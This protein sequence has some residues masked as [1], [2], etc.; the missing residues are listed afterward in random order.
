MDK[1]DDQQRG[2]GTANCEGA[3]L[4]RAC[5][6]PAAVML[7]GVPRGASTIGCWPIDRDGAIRMVDEG[8]D[9]D[10][11][12][13]E[14]PELIVVRPH[15]ASNNSVTTAVKFNIGTALGCIVAAQAKSAR[16]NIE[17]ANIVPLRAVAHP[18]RN[19]E[20]ATW[21]AW[22]HRRSLVAIQIGMS[23]A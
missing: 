14:N 23:P 20:F 2:A 11:V 7:I 19:H 17:D 13:R 15:H 12:L 10:S 1:A 16:G 3:C 18:S 9:R 6:E 4:E 21:L 22:F 5:G 8:L